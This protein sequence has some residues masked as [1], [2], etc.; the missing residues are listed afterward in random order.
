MRKIIFDADIII[1]TSSVN[2]I[3]IIFVLSSTPVI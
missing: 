3:Q 1:F 2:R